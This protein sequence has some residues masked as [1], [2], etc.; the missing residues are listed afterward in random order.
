METGN[1]WKSTDINFNDLLQKQ[2]KLLYKRGNFLGF[3][4]GIGGK[5]HDF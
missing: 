3:L 1:E 4:G 2:V 5:Y